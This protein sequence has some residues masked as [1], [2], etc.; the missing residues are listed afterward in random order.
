ML[1]KMTKT[2]ELPYSTAQMFSLV[3]RVEDYPLFLP[4]CL[5]SQVHSRSAEEVKASLQVGKGLLR[6]SVTTLNRLQTPKRIDMQLLAGPFKHLEGFW[7]FE[8]GAASV[9]GCKI[10]LHLNFELNPL[11]NKALEPFSEKIGDRIIQAFCERAA[12]LYG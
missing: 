11:L 12:V 1:N 10:S 3:D 7:L 6:Y 4:W 9:Q 8:G 2:I 5:K